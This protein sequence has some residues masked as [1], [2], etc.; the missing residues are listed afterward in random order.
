MPLKGRLSNQTPRPVERRDE[1]PGTEGSAAN[2]HS[3][4]TPEA[5][6]ETRRALARWALD[7]LRINERKKRHP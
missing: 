4:I 1:R 2:V 7:I 3:R 6:A 5:L